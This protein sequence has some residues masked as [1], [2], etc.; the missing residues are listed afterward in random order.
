MRTV[1]RQERHMSTPEV[2]TDCRAHNAAQRAHYELVELELRLLK[3]H[4]KNHVDH[5]PLELFT[6][7]RG[8]VRTIEEL[9]ALIR[10]SP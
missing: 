10:S 8:H 5:I 9:G 2:D 7:F 1:Q 4:I 3:I 6:A